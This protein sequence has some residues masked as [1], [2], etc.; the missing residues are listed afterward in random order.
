MNDALQSYQD[1]AV[2]EDM[3]RHAL[4][5]KLLVKFYVKAVR[6]AFKSNEAGRPIF[7]EL[8]YVRI[9]TPGNQ[10]SIVDTQ[11][12]PREKARFADIYAKF[13]AGLG[14]AR[15]GTPLEVWPQ[16][17]VGQVAELKAM[18]IE[19]V[20]D[21]AGLDDNL[22]Q[23]IMGNHD[24]RRRAQAF[25][26]SAKNEAANSKLASELEKRD[27]QIAALQAQMEQMLKAQE[28]GPKLSDSVAA[29]APSAKE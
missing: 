9:I 7:D 1:A 11:A 13:K 23:K 24:L 20:E 28:K 29:K 8:E 14:Q 4:D 2:M 18:N 27:L 15:S 17:T 26:D 6:N 12:T 16:M 22:A 19:T 25:L 3:P 21:L 5:K 10:L